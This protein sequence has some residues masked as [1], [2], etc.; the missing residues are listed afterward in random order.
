MCAIP[1]TVLRP[2]FQNFTHVLVMVWTCA[3][4]LD[5]ILKL[6]CHFFH[7]LNLGIFEAILHLKWKD[8]RYQLFAQLRQQF[9]AAYFKTLQMFWSWSEDVHVVWI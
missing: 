3:C 1:L 2:F 8:S 4:G 5:F 9:Y 6:F 7:K